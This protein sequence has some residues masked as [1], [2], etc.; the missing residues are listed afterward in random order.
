MIYIDVSVLTLVTFV[1]GIQRVTREVVLRIIEKDDT[2]LKLLHYNSKDECYRIIDNKKFYNFYKNDQGIKQRMITRGKVH[3]EDIGQGDVWVD[4]D[5]AWMAKERRSYLLP[6][7]K[8][9]GCAI[10]SH[11]YDIISVTHPQ[12]CLERSVYNFSDYIGAHLLYDDEIIVNAKATRDE[13]EKIVSKSDIK[14]PGCHV[15]YLGA[16]FAND[17]KIEKKE[18]AKE[19]AMAIEDSKYLLMVG[20]VEPRKNHKLVLDA[21]EGRGITGDTPSLKEQGYKLIIAGSMG[22]NMEDF[23]NR[24]REHPDMGK[25]IFL[26]EGLGDKDISFLY[27][28][29][30]YLIFASYVEGFGL[31]II[32]GVMKGTRVVCA[33]VPVLREIGENKCL[34]FRQDDAQSLAAVIYEDAL[35]GKTSIKENVD[36]NTFSWNNTTDEILQILRSINEKSTYYRNNR[37]RRIIFG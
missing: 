20:T 17:R 30:E 1:T 8:S 5:A 29:A 2:V 16:N 33:D 34:W 13:L 6:I 18:V 11:I 35:N 4:L 37:S 26:F 36:I 25:E 15:V 3:V 31:P 19:V 9:Q 28:N 32:E 22:W 27:Q 12:Y 14:L 21:F 23:E 7:L 10:V 24:L